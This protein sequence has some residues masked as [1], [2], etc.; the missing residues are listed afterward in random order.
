MKNVIISVIIFF[1]LLIGLFVSLNYL[2]S[3]CNDL[4]NLGDK[5]E[6]EISKE[7]WQEAY[8]SS[9]NL[10]KEWKNHCDV[11]SFFVHH[12]EID[13]ID[14]ELWKLSQYTKCQTKDESLASVH[15]VKFFINH[16]KNLEDLSIQNIF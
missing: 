14:N 12:Q 16:I 9:M 15:V 10:T 8:D 7:N 13:N 2:S 5:I 3:M 4:V 1:A 6:D 11:I